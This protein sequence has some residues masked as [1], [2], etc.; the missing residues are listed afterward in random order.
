M[1]GVVMSIAEKIQ[2]ILEQASW[3]RKMFEET[4]FKGEESSQPNGKVTVSVGYARYN[5]R[6]KNKVVSDADKAL[7]EAKKKRNA[8]KG[9]KYP[10]PK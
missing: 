9:A 5:P 1:G 6:A 7:Y 3:I 2:A 8:V 10:R 4:P